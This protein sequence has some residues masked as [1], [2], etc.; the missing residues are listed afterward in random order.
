MPLICA[1]VTLIFADAFAAFF[2]R[3]AVYAA[4]TRLMV[5]SIDIA[6]LRR[7]FFLR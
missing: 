2:T 1:A 5:P 3:V 4:D 6:A 7:V